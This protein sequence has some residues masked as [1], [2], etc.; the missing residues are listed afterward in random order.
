VKNDPER[1]FFARALMKSWGRARSERANNTMFAGS[2]SRVTGR[3][4]SH[5]SPA[6]AGVE[7]RITELGLRFL[8]ACRPPGQIDE[9]KAH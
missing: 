8:S 9:D 4:E 3:F 1:K 5:R 7:V 2:R 6:V